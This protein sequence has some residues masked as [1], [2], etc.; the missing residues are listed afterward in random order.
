MYYMCVIV[1]KKKK[2]YIRYMCK[3]YSYKY[4]LKRIPEAYSKRLK[5]AIGISKGGLGKRLPLNVKI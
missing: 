3:Y 1:T 4:Y 2:S 5:R